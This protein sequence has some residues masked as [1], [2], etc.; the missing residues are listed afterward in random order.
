V[1]ILTGLTPTSPLPQRG[2]VSKYQPMWD[3][4]SQLAPEQWIAVAVEDIS[5]RL[6]KNKASTVR[7]SAHRATGRHLDVL[8]EAVE[9]VEH[10]FMRFAAEPVPAPPSTPAPSSRRSGRRSSALP[11]A[12]EPSTP[13]PTPDPWALVQPIPTTEP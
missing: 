2:S 10:L 5:G 4:L 7:T 8:Q 11:A 6:Y 1:K 12:V 9:G 3:Q 13:A